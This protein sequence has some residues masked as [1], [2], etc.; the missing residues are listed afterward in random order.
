MRVRKSRRRPGTGRAGR[1]GASLRIVSAALI[2]ALALVTGCRDR[3]PAPAPAIHPLRAVEAA[4][5]WRA[6]S[7]REDFLLLDIRTPAEFERERIPGAVNLDFHAASFREDLSSLDRQQTILLYC[8]SGNRSGQSLGLFQELGFK[9][10]R[11]LEGGIL[12]WRGAGLP[13]EAGRP[14]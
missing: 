12:A 10:V 6:Q 2:M 3:G 5:L 1:S 13:V 7:G 14:R 8:R 4:E 9:D 11:H